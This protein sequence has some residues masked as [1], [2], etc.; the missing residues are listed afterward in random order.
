[1]NNKDAHA[2]FW[3]LS[4]ENIEARKQ[5]AEHRPELDLWLEKVEALAKARLAEIEAQEVAA[6]V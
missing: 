6:E 3:W 2:V 5:L 4:P 1:M